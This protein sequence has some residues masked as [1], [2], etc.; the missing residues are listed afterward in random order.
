M[1]SHL[2][3][4]KNGSG[5]RIETRVIDSIG[6]IKPLL[7]PKAWKIFSELCRRESYPA[8]LAKRLGL[9]QQEAYY[10]VNKLRSAGLVEVV[11]KEEKKGG[12]AKY[13]AAKDRCFSLLPD[14]PLQGQNFSVPEGKEKEL[15]SAIEEFFSPFISNGVL[16]AKIVIGSPDSHG[17]FRARARDA[18]LAVELS[19]FLGSLSKKIRAP[20]VFLDTMAKGLKEENSNLIIIGGP[21]TNTLSRQVNGFLSV[22]FRQK[23]AHWVIESKNSGREY[24]EDNVGIVEKISHPFFEKRG[25]LFL[26]GKR[27]AGTRASVLS[28][29]QNTSETVSC[30]QFR[31]GVFAHAVEGLDLDSDGKIDAVELK[32]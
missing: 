10:Y 17:E 20:M 13:F 9:G 18:H 21:I 8:E 31:E 29:I 2:V 26:A 19:A 5:K 11:K 14:F 16:D 25:I 23:N 7:N 30:N 1:A 6:P 4:E 32:E 15:D 3:F 22:S 24:T 28:L 27:N 12:L